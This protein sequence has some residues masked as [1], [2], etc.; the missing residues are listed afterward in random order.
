MQRHH[1]HHCHRLCH[2]LPASTGSPAATRRCDSRVR[3]F[4][5]IFHFLVQN[6]F[7]CGGGRDGQH[8]PLLVFMDGGHREHRAAS[9]LARCCAGCVC[10]ADDEIINKRCATLS[11]SMPPL[12]MPATLSVISHGCCRCCRRSSVPL[13]M[14]FAEFRVRLARANLE[15]VVLAWSLLSRTKALGS[16]L[17]I[18]IWSCV[19]CGDRLWLRVERVAM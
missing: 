17:V 14:I 19:G 3:R 13:A 10:V 4:G 11:N 9:R 7:A 18:L 16:D 2:L 8:H 5:T 15:F 6:F 1:R 12:R